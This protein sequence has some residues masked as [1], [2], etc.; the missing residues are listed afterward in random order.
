MKSLMILPISL[1]LVAAACGGSSTGPSGPPAPP[2]PQHKSW[3]QQ[4][5]AG[6]LT[7]CASVEL[8]LAP[9]GTGLTA[10]TVRM[11]NL[12]GAPGTIP[13]RM[14]NLTFANLVTDDT[15]LGSSY[16]PLQA[17]LSGTSNFHVDADSATC[18]GSCAGASWGRTEWSTFA[19]PGTGRGGFYW[20]INGAGPWMPS[21]VGC[22]VP[23]LAPSNFSIGWGAFRTCGTGWVEIS[24]SLSGTWTFDDASSQVTWHAFSDQGDA[25]CMVGLNCTQSG[26]VSPIASASRSR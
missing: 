23:V 17:V 26:V 13:F 6:S 18:A 9:S 20:V 16:R 24:L 19:S 5:T 21:M 25:S 4:C 12:Q 10:V 2:A 22:E 3:L 1:A 15:L 8:I 7:F 14:E 11:R